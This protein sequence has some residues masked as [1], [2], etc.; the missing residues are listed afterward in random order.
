MI[1]YDIIQYSTISISIAI[2]IAIQH[3]FPVCFLCS[4]ADPHG[5]GGHRAAAGP[6]GDLPLQGGVAWHPALGD[7]TALGG[8]AVG[9]RGGWPR[10]AVEKG[11][12]AM[13]W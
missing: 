2:A 9:P 13:V 11:S 6:P 10:V 8:D 3:I 12:G 7:R 5:S 4:F 1:Q